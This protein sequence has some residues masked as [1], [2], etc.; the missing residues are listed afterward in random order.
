MIVSNLSSSSSFLPAYNRAWTWRLLFVRRFMKIFFHAR[1]E[2]IQQEGIRWW[3]VT[4]FVLI[5]PTHALVDNS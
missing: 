5:A 4:R 3:G 2:E 1:R